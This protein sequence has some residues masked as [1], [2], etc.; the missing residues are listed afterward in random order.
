MRNRYLLYLLLTACCSSLLGA[1]EKENDE[2][3]AFLDGSIADVLSSAEKMPNTS[4]PKSDQPKNS[5]PANPSANPAK[6]DKVNCDE[7]HYQSIFVK[8]LERGKLLAVDRWTLF[9]KECNSIEIYRESCIRTMQQEEKK[10]STATELYI[11]CD[12]SGFIEGMIAGM[13]TIEA[14]CHN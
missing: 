3:L 12:I 5:S 13:K 6:E 1:C 4:P 11:K 14:Q 7:P 8:A 10:I 9:H 2:T